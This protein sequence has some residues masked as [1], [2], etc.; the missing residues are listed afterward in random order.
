FVSIVEADCHTRAAFLN[1]KDTDLCF[2]NWL[3]FIRQYATCNHSTSACA[4]LCFHR[5]AT[6]NRYFTKPILDMAQ[7]DFEFERIVSLQLEPGAHDVRCSYSHEIAART[8]IGKNE[9]AVSV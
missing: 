5:T 8:N 2:R 1:S 3:V 9:F 7:R 6:V 4:N